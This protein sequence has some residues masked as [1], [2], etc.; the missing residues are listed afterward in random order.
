VLNRMV[1]LYDADVRRT[2]RYDWNAPL[3]E[4]RPDGARDEYGQPG[5]YGQQGYSG[6]RGSYDRLASPARELDGRA[7]PAHE[8]AEGL[9]GNAGG[10][11]HREYFDRI[12]HFN[13]Q[14]RDFDQRVSSGQSDYRELRDE[15]RHLSDDARQADSQMRANNVFPEVWEEWRGAMQVLER[16]LNVLG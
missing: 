16:I 1:R 7:A 4:F 9:M 13:D 11:A 6:R 8:L 15:A 12:H 14:A 2:G 5:Y 10:R 3:P